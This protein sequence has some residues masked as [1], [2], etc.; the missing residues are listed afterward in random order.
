MKAVHLEERTNTTNGIELAEYFLVIDE[1]QQIPI[2]KGLKNNTFEDG[3]RTAEIHSQRRSL[4]SRL[5]VHY[6]P[7]T[8]TILEYFT[9]TPVIDAIIENERANIHPGKEREI[10]F[11]MLEEILKL[12]PFALN[13][14]RT[15]IKTLGKHQATPELVTKL[16]EAYL[17]V[18]PYRQIA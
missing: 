16:R 2:G 18:Y 11:K 7:P 14:E 3:H 13:P 10:F 8:P 12:D 15:S 6:S 1:T 4:A 17:E 5:G 9:Q